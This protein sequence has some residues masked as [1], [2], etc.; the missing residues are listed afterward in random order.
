CLVVA[1]VVIG[2]AHVRNRRQ[3][4][5]RVVL[6]GRHAQRGQSIAHQ[7]VRV[8]LIGR[9][10]LL[11]QGELIDIV[12]G[13]RQGSVGAVVLPGLAVF[14]VVIGVGRSVQSLVVLLVHRRQ[15][16]RC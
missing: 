13:V 3:L 1:V 15:Q 11:G 5:R 14:H 4:V 16:A 2:V 8:A 6:I 10:P 7:I 9:S 12:E